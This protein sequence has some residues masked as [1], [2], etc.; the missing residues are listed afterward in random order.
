MKRPWIK[1]KVKISIVKT[2]IVYLQYLLQ[3][4]AHI[5]KV[6]I[7]MITMIAKIRITVTI[8]EKKTTSTLIMTAMYVYISGLYICI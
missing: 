8:T 1:I 5:T 7:V 6:T 3:N 2:Y 4:M